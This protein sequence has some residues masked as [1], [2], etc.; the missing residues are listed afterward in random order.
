MNS[1]ASSSKACPYSPVCLGLCSEWYDCPGQGGAK[2]FI[3]PH[4]IQALSPPIQCDELRPS[5]S[6]QPLPPSERFHFVDDKNLLELAKGYTPA[7]TS[8]STKWA[9]KVYQLW[10][11]VNNQRHPT[12][13]VP[14]D[15][16]TTCDPVL[17]NKHL[18][19]FAV[20]ARKTNGDHY[21]PSTIHQLL[22]GLLRHARDQSPGCPNF[23]DKQ[24][25]RFKHLQGT[26]DALFHKLHS[27]G[28]GVQTKH[29]EILTKDDEEKLW[30]SG[31]MGMATPR[32]LQ[33]AAF[34][35]AGKMFSL[36]GGVEH[37]HLKVSQLQRHHQPDHYV[38]HENVS[39]TNDGSFKKLRI[40][41]KVV[42]VYACSDLGERCPVKIL[43][44]YLSKLPPKA[45]VDDI[46]YLR[47]L[48]KIPTDHSLPWYAPVPVGKDTLQNKLSTMCKQAGVLGNKTNHS[49]RAA[50]ATQMYDSGV[51]EKLI[52]ER[53]G[54]RSLEALRM[55]ERTNMRQHQAVS[56][57]LS[58]P[59]S[60]SYNHFMESKQMR[61]AY[62]A[63]QNNQH[64]T[65]S[66]SFNNLHGC[67]IN[68]HNTPVAKSPQNTTS[69]HTD[70]EAE[71]DKLIASIQD[72]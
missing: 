64:A 10:C 36:R 21:P 61:V 7:N 12:E 17:L 25:S 4:P 13:C 70:S 2:P 24:Y 3:E 67:T 50:G 51:P 56:N 33:N 32:A 48:S 43:D 68:I 16:L 44:T 71:L 66:F 41:G 31:I 22:C 54:H 19:R 14:E 65:T 23:L 28:I 60:T 42:P 1:E 26:L 62:T 11:E 38:Y 5:S 6:S 30:T 55:Y 69:S 15:L 18:S 72:Y 59:H 27:D 49:L 63:P 40:K 20:E 53:T 52:Q 47:P 58:T 45:H 29:T 57:L 8:R 39:K 35:V 46:F 37:R 34:F 9:L